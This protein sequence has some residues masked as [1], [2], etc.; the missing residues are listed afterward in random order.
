MGA[1]SPRNGTWPLESKVPVL[2]F[3]DY[4]LWL[5]SSGSIST[6]TRMKFRTPRRDW[7]SM[8]VPH[9]TSVSL[10]S[11]FF[12]SLS[13]FCSF[14]SFFLWLALVLSSVKITISGGMGWNW[15]GVRVLWALAENNSP[16]VLHCDQPDPAVHRSLLHHH[17][18]L[19]ESQHGSP[20]PSSRKDRQWQKQV[21][22]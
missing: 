13:S 20:R 15:A 11:S 10:L 9:R 14:L 19:H 21:L 7:L 2:S 8:Q 4:G 6:A 3:C 1:V 17:L 22:V 12:L 5:G 16:T 18:L